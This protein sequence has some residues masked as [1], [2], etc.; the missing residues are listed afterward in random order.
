[1]RSKL[2]ACMLVAAA[3]AGAQR[4]N[5][6][7]APAAAAPS[8]FRA[9]LDKHQREALR[10]VAQYVASHPDADDVEQ[11]SSWMF[12]TAVAQG[13]EAEV[14]GP[15]E[16]FLK[17]RG[18]DQPSILLAQQALSMGLARTGKRAEAL[19]VFDSY[20][21][22]VRYQSPF[23]T[24]E[25]ASSL[26]AQARIAG[27][28]AGSREIFE[29]LASAYPLNA[30]LGEIVE[31][32]IARQE[33]IGQPVPRFGA[34]DVEGKRLE[35]ADYSG[36]VVLVDFWATTCAPCL[37]EFPNLRQLYK[38]YHEKGFEIVGVS[39]DDGPDTVQ[40]FVA[41]ARLPWRM[42]MDE[43][44]EGVVSQRFKTKTIPALFL[45]DRKGNVAQVDVRGNDLRAVIEKLLAQ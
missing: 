30:Q 32:R 34:S 31:G 13:L 33:L 18:L 19:S 15:A 14:V 29:R 2:T 6:D 25:L 21:K 17:R 3:I 1:M 28:L 27:D 44:A 7:D 20:L 8:G 9:L 40:A 26:S 37:A 5:A 42:V 22:G 24:L 12:E 45:I 35:M 38:E 4:A 23:R 16:Q 10:S 43:S 41:R 11:A 36:K 39:F